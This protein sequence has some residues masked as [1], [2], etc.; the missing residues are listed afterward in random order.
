MCHFQA[1]N[2]PIC[3]EQNF[4]VQ[5]I[6]ITFIYLLAIFIG[7]NLKK[8]LTA[9]PD[10]WCIIFGPKMAHL[11]QTN[12]FF[13]KKSLISFSSTYWPLLLC[14]SLK[15]FLQRIQGYEDASVLGPK[16]PICPNT[17]FFRKLVNKPC[18]FHSSLSTCQKSK[19]DIYLL[20]KYWQLKNTEI[21]LAENNFWL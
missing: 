18:S 3:P 13:G 20:M 6:I 8:L 14:K 21:S 17:N 12:F 2:S 19:S 4:L 10:L 11:P 5:T 16:Q 7:Q 1:K 15:K 9:N